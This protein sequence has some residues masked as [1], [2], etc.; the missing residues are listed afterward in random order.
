LPKS[1]FSYRWIKSGPERV[2][3]VPNFATSIALCTLLLE[4][5]VFSGVP[6][7]FDIGILSRFRYFD[8]EN[9]QFRDSDIN[10]DINNIQ[11]DEEI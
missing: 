10:S 3:D 2:R 4:R 1:D 7:A 9:F 11:I 5:T 8:I 6:R